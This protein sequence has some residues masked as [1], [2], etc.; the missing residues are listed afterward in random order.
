M[1]KQEEKVLNDHLSFL[2]LVVYPEGIVTY[3]E[4]FWNYLTLD[5][6]KELQE[7]VSFKYTAV[8]ARRLLHERGYYADYEKPGTA[9]EPPPITTEPAKGKP[10]GMPKWAPLALL[11]ILGLVLFKG[12]S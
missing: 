9:S 6:T 8:D 10:F 3:N 11:G 12:K 7:K 2:G 1:T 5:L 4:V